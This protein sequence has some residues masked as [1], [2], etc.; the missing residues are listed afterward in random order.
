MFRF[1]ECEQESIQAFQKQGG[2]FMNAQ[3]K[4]KLFS[5][6]PKLAAFAMLFAVACA[7]VDKEPIRQTM[8]N[9]ELTIDQARSSDASRYAPLSLKRAEEKLEDARTAFKNRRYKDADYLAEEALVEAKLA[10]SETETAKTKTIVEDL[11][12][13][14]LE[15]R[16]EL[17]KNKMEQ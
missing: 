15:L 12:N 6:L 7:S 9:A 4:R 11:Q 14:I 5:G 2:R 1:S 10:L 8:G 16:E 17:D 3:K 13:S